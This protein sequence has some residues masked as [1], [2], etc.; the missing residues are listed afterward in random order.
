[1]TLE[2]MRK[3]IDAIDEKLVELLNE[4]CNVAIEIGKWKKNLS[5]PVYAPGREKE[6]LEH[7]YAVNQGPVSNGS[8]RAIFR[9]IM[10][11]AIALE[12]SKKIAYDSSVS[13]THTAAVSK[14]GSSTEYI[15]KENTELVFRD[16]SAGKVDYGCVQIENHGAFIL[17]TM[18]LFLKYEVKICAEIY[19][20]ANSKQRFA[21]I[22]AD[23][24]VIS[25]HT[26][27][28]KT[29]LC[30]EQASTS[31]DLGATF[32]KAG[33]IPLM[34][35]TAVSDGTKRIFMDIPGHPG[36]ESMRSMLNALQKSVKSISILGVYPKQVTDQ[37]SMSI[38][39]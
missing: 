33:I 35:T 26:G 36:D 2:E 7:V 24:N 18:E 8:L 16:V 20:Y 11:G 25:T 28:D 30:L 27:Y 10:S 14:F 31:M 15:A 38:E 23:S 19:I 12:Q 4:R 21:I 17:Q 13:S 29:T 37:S 34:A 9:E 22:A 1:M 6:V 39:I 32:R 3:K 5:V